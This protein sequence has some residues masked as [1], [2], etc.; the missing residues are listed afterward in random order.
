M[1]SV[2][3]EGRIGS[4]ELSLAFNTYKK[5][6]E[7]KK[8]EGESSPSV[9]EEGKS[10]SS[11]LSQFKK[12]IFDDTGHQGKKRK[13]SSGSSTIT[14]SMENVSPLT[15]KPKV[16]KLKVLETEVGSERLVNNQPTTSEVHPST[17]KPRGKKA[18]VLDSKSN[19]DTKLDSE[20][21]INNQA[22][23][24]KVHPLPSK[25]KVND[26]GSNLSLET[27]T[28]NPFSPLKV[29][30]LTSESEGEK[31]RDLKIELDSKSIVHG[32]R[33]S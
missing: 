3:P 8:E 21:I 9:K 23:P 7:L 32:A 20:I 4:I 17:S 13:S 6:L 33:F 15:S 26:L 28:I 2:I 25:L 24:M 31:F 19:L 14:C 1:A 27:L 16:K 29:P 10:T 30:L 18:K 11:L 5:K 12:S 22:K